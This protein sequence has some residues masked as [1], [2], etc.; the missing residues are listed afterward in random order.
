VNAAGDRVEGP[1]GSDALVRLVARDY[2]EGRCSLA[3]AARRLGVNRV[4][5][6]RLLEQAG[7]AI[8]RQGRPRHSSRL[9]TILTEDFLRHEYEQSGRTT[10]ELAD[11][12]GCSHKTILRY[13]RTFGIELRPRSARPLPAISRDDLARWFTEDGLSAGEIAQQLGCATKTV[14]EALARWQIRRPR[15]PGG[16]VVLSPLWLRDAYVVRGLSTTDIAAVAGCAPSTVARRLREAGIV[17]RGR[18]GGR[19]PAVRRQLRTAGI[20]RE[21]IGADS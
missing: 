2:A 11:T 9:A 19:P 20:R 21:L 3:Q 17:L 6:K 15:P 10:A 5:T 16:P 12:L 18:G 1:A 7:V 4:V 14:R 13:L 8:R